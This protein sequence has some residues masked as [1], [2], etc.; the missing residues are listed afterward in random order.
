MSESPSPVVD[1]W[2]VDVDTVVAGCVGDGSSSP[3]PVAVI[4]IIATAEHTIRRRL[5]VWD[6]AIWR[7]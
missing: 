2:P 7:V 4:A 5:L 6:L 1:T 3:H